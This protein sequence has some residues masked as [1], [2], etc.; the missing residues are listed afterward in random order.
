MLQEDIFQESSLCSNRKTN[1]VTVERDEQFFLCALYISLLMG[2]TLVFGCLKPGD[3][4][5]ELKT[6]WH[7]IGSLNAGE[8]ILSITQEQHLAHKL[9]GARYA[10]VSFF[11]T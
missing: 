2:V 1:H 3:G 4:A 11:Y 7:L 9:G 8:K 10:S 5:A 6:C